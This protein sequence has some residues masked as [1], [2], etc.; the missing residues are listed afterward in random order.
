MWLAR[1]TFVRI[2]FSRASGATATVAADGRTCD[3]ESAA[4]RMLRVMA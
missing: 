4:S 1:F 2:S 3:T